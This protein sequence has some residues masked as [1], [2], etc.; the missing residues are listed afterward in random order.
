M[1]ADGSRGFKAHTA[2]REILT[3]QIEGRVAFVAPYCVGWNEN[4]RELYVVVVGAN[5]FIQKSSSIYYKR[6]Y[7]VGS[8]EAFEKN[9][10]HTY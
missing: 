1:I 8:F 6:H 3:Q 5:I 10:F 9:I 7:F 2:I 4:E